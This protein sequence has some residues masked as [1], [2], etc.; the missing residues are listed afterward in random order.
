MRRRIYR[1]FNELEL[2]RHVTGAKI[3]LELGARVPLASG[4]VYWSKFFLECELR[5]LLDVVTVVFRVAAG[6]RLRAAFSWIEGVSAIFKE[7]NVGYRVDPLGIVHFAID[8]EF[9]HV[10]ACAVAALQDARYGAARSHYEAGQRALDATP[11]ETREAIRQTF[12]CVETIFK[13][14]FPD[15][16]RLGSTEATKKIKPC[17]EAAYVGTERD[18]LAR[19][20][21]A[22]KEWINGA[23]PYRHGQGVEEPDNPSVSTAV[24]SVT[25]ASAF[26]RWLA[27]LDARRLGLD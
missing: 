12:D 22:F 14:M 18:S 6:K 10:Q 8:G 27:E 15:V 26:I 17:L 2:S 11:P 5:D 16:A 20:L 23:H 9:E 3:E 19:M 4:A 1:L 13:L 7:E 24:L 21:D 25:I